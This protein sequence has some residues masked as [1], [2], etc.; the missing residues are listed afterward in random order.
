MLNG[1]NFQLAFSGPEGQP[2]KVMT[3]TDLTQPGSWTVIST[4]VFGAVLAVFTD[5]N[6]PSQPDRFYRVVS[7]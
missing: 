1:G 2:Y 7:P 6:A 5:T 4:G 3:T